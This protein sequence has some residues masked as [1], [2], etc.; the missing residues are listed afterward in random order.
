MNRARPPG[1][2]LRAFEDI[3]TVANL[4]SAIENGT[5]LDQSKYQCGFFTG[6][7]ASLRTGRSNKWRPET[8]ITGKGS[9]VIDH[10]EEKFNFPF[11]K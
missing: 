7:R 8:D 1:K 10:S 6:K 11:E 3:Q 2:L 5:T 9:A 4:I